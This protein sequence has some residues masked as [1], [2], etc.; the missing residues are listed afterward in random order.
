MID[1]LLTTVE[2]LAITT[3]I[4]FALALLL[5]LGRLSRV[6]ALAW[7]AGGIVSVLRGTP[8][9]AQI[10]LIY[11]GLAQFAAI[12]HSVLWPVLRH[13]WPCAVL[14]LSINMGAYTS[15]VLRA[16]LLAVPRGEREAGAALGLSRTQAW[17]LIV[18]PR[19]IRIGWPALTNEV[20]VQLKATSLVSTI[21]VLDL[22]GKARRLAAASFSPVP[23]IEAGAIYAMLALGIGGVSQWLERRARASV[24][25][26]AGSNQAGRGR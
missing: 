26:A 15:E 22:T 9:L 8:L 16:A 10:F 17:R 12:R 24:S 6:R 18:L 4:G 19:A 3:V 25:G 13:A 21:T 11:Y 2:L 14:A 1:A 5:A 23:L 7:P 20:L